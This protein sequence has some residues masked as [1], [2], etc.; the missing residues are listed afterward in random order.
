M[1]KGLIVPVLVATLAFVPTPEAA[2][3]APQA[4]SRAEPP[5]LVAPGF[6]SAGERIPV[7]AFAYRGRCGPTGLRFDDAPVAHRLTRYAG[8]PPSDRVEM[9]MTLDVPATATR[10]RH[11]IQLY[12][13]GPQARCPAGSAT[14]TRLAVGTVILGP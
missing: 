13:P 14:P 3:A 2:P 6:A 5:R 11:E 8:S 10:G 12:G 1:H 7:L 4:A 9:F